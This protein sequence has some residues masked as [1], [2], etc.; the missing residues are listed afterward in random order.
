MILSK[1]QNLLQIITQHKSKTNDCLSKH[2][3]NE[4]KR[5]IC[6]VT[7]ANNPFVRC[8]SRQNRA[9]SVKHQTFVNERQWLIET[10]TRTRQ[11]TF[12]CRGVPRDPRVG[13][14]HIFWWSDQVSLV[15]QISPLVRGLFYSHM[16]GGCDWQMLKFVG[17]D[18][19]F[20]V[21]SSTYY[22]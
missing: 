19:D 17:A 18:I 2:L 21:T 12:T 22:V 20:I 3:Y 13:S 7:K 14:R 6:P 8:W 15:L 1:A 5:P 9:P 16:S 11:P 10:Y 4:S